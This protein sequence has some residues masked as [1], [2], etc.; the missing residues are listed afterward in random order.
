MRKTLTTLLALFVATL[1][2]L[3]QQ[4]LFQRNLGGSGTENSYGI[5]QTFD[6]GFISVG[7]TTSFGKGKKDVYLV[8]TDGLGGIE[9]AK[10]YG[11]SGDDVGWNVSVTNDS[12]YVVVGTTNSYN[13][14]N[15]DA[16]IFK[17]D[18]NGKIEWTQTIASDSIED[19]YNVIRSFFGSGFYIAGYVKNDTTGDDGFLAKL[20]GSGKVRWY[21]K[22]GSD[23]NDE[24]YG[25]AEDSKGN[26]VLC[27]M[28]TYDSI[29][30]GGLTG[31][32]GNSDAFVAKFDSTGNFKWMKTV[33]SVAD[34]VAWDIKTDK[35]A[36]VMAG[37]TKAISAGDNDMMFVV[38][39]T[40][41]TIQSSA[42][43]G[44]QGNDR[45][46]DVIVKPGN[47]SEYAVVGYTDPMNGN[48]E[49]VYAEYN[50]SAQ[51]SGFSIIGGSNTDGHWP[52][53]ITN[54]RDGGFAILSTSNSFGNS[55]GDDWYL[56][57][58]NSRGGVNCNEVSD[59]LQ[60]STINFASKSFGSVTTGLTTSIP[61]LSTT[62]VT[63]TKDSTLCCKLSAQVPKAEIEICEGATV[64]IGVVETPG[65]LYTWTDGSGSSVSKEANPSVKPSETTTYKLVVS[66][67]DGK[68]VKDSS[69]VKVTVNTL[70]KED[71]VRDSS[72]CDGDSIILIGSSNLVNYGWEGNHISA[73]GKSIKIKLH[74]TIYFT[75]SDINSCTYRDTSII[76]VY[77]LP[78]FSLGNDTTICEVDGITL[79]GPAN[80]K[81]YDWNNGE[82]SQQ[83]VTTST[84]KTF[85]LEVVDTNGCMFTD[86][87]R[88][89][90]NPSSPFSLG[91][92]DTFCE[93][94]TYTILGP[95]ALSNYV[96]NDTASSLQNITVSQ[97]G[98]YHLR[99]S[100]SF[101]CPSY[102]TIK[103]FQ[104]K[105]P[106]FDLGPDVGLCL[107]G[108]RW[109]VGPKDMASYRWNTSS[110][111][112]S[113][114][115]VSS[116]K[117]W[118]RVTDK[119]ACR[120]TDTINVTD[121]ANPTI[122][123]RNDTTICI[124]D[125]LLLTPGAGFAEYD[126]N[127]GSTDASIYAKEA[128]EYSV[129]VTDG[130][131]CKGSASMTLDTM[132]CNDAIENLKLAELKY[133][134]VP[135][136]ERV[137]ISFEAFNP[138]QMVIRIVDIAGKT[139]TQT[140]HDTYVG[141]N[142]I[143]LDVEGLATGSY[144]V[145]LNNSNGSAALKILV[146]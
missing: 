137:F 34:D 21:K 64:K 61:T 126:W 52:T 48:Q 28:T 26:V 50:S 92:D 42:V 59:V 13:K 131:G 54:T 143:E 81:S 7:Y 20:S 140:S 68:C 111:N 75:G 78:S 112:D 25:L 58:T 105:Q 22:F 127:T 51:L 11:G 36:Y 101:N 95:G 62:D 77:N 67:K 102:D 10:A 85:V 139:M 128:R 55:S 60:S 6:G 43:S 1:T 144:F 9:W 69:T 32:S 40:N 106:V 93:G 53:D 122:S 65:M 33:G 56:I 86:D 5:E 115:V 138:D 74:D 14:S 79:T 134:P 45:A 70:L 8:K 12:G 16:L 114:R 88:V 96:W 63:T 90:T 133:Y 49:V 124:G 107:G 80:M 98:T 123:L 141:K 91:A 46:F 87:I 110:S 24:A 71:F 121:V 108:S 57:K 109:L 99:A 38:T 37:W 113:L 73:T 72:M 47:N 120:W 2:G 44:S 4:T 35:N 100:N 31:H 17:T 15:D 129:T 29:T 118:L 41:G 132:T 89:L 39:D 145:W 3:A 117:Y 76:T 116:G 18:K 130:N 23:G 146:E 30:Q 142:E 125:S 27:G 19:G 104:R 66:S 84:S 119:Y 82:S 83:S 135:A 94:G 97:A 103:L 136:S